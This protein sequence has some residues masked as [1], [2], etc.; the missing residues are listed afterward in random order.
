MT[1]LAGTPLNAVAIVPNGTQTFVIDA[2][3]K[4]EAQV[5]FQ[6]AFTAVAATNGLQAQVFP[7]VGTG[8]TYDTV[9]AA[10]I[11]IAGTASSTQ[12]QTL[13]LPTGKYQ[14][15][16]TNLDGT[17]GITVTV[18]WASIDATQ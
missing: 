12:N 11:V 6:C 1:M 7:G 13:K 16:V 15:R 9:A 17:N 14:F 2:S 8:P 18:I 5:Q 3:P 10:T 4:F